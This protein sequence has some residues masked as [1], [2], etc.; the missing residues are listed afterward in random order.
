MAHSTC[1]LAPVLRMSI[2]QYFAPKDGF[3]DVNGSLSGSILSRSIA[4]ASREVARVTN[5]EKL[6]VVC[7]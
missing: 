2:R 1:I 5:N 7:R 4:C 3:S 6:S